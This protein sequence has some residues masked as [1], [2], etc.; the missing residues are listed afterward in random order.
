MPATQITEEQLNL[1]ALTNT[2][3]ARLAYKA[4]A[5]RISGLVY[6]NMRGLI[7]D[8]VRTICHDAVTLTKSAA[9]V[10]VQPQH[11]RMALDRNGRKIYAGMVKATSKCSPY[12]KRAKAPTTQGGAQRRWRP[13]TVALRKIK[14]H[15]KQSECVYLSKRA[16][17]TL[18]RALD[19]DG[20]NTAGFRWSGA[21]MGLLQMATEAYA[22]E[23]LRAALDVMASTRKKVTLTAGDLEIVRR[24]QTSMCGQI[25]RSSVPSLPSMSQSGYIGSVSPV[26]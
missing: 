4:G 10:T 2:A 9:K 15:Q 8:F 18:V 7:L 26:L 1:R 11:V 19:V 25:F 16:F 6:E 17:S 3:I 24:L 12:S 22:V 14:F 23:T 21:A 13:G 20:V 5:K